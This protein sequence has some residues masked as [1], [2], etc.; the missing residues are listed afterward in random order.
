MR[1]TAMQK[2]WLA[3]YRQSGDAAAAAR[4][5]GYAAR[6]EKDWR[7]IGER[8]RRLLAALEGRSAAGEAAGEGK[9]AAVEPAAA[10]PADG[11]EPAGEGPDGGGEAS[12]AAAA[13]AAPG[14]VADFE[15]I[16]AFWTAVMRSEDESAAN[17]LKASELCARALGVF[18]DKNREGGGPVIICGEEA[19]R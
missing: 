18:A 2:R 11:A 19:I 17:R 9:A 5:A 13:G 12:A 3:Y 8:N 6:D 16:C 7:A 4:Q 1:L 15:E 14:P 10:E